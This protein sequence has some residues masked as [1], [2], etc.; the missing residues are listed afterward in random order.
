[1]INWQTEKRPMVAL[2]PMTDMTDS[3]FCRIAKQLGCRI[4]FREMISAEAVVRAN[5]KTLSMA[6][7]NDEERPIVQQ[8][9]GS[10][11]LIMAEAT[12]IIDEQFNPD[13]FDINMGCPAHKIIGGFN[14]AALMREPKLAAKIIAAVKA[15]TTKQVS[16]KTRL[17]WSQPNEILEFSKIVEAAGA[18]LL[19]IHGR[20]KTQGYAGRADWEMI[21]RARQQVTLPILANGDIFSAE[22]ARE[23]LRVTSCAGVL[24]A[25]GALGNPWI[26]A[27]IESALTPTSIKPRPKIDLATIKK[28]VLQHAQLHSELHGGNRPLTSFRKHLA[29]YFR[30]QPG[31]KNIRLSLMQ[32]ET[33]EQLDKII[34]NLV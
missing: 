19:S 8:L 9:F 2:A 26:F 23:A 29:W 15:A 32:V 5:E 10:D 27:E 14:G 24:V 33:I 13:A 6:T 28:T 17:G 16:V 18:D 30:G 21:G 7:F 25:R 4:V 31:S 22:S 34:E 11:P 20:T 1:M 3:A 12:R